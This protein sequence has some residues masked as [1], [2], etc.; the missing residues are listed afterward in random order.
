MNEGFIPLRIMKVDG[1]FDD[2]IVALRRTGSPGG[3]RSKSVTAGSLFFCPSIIPTGVWPR[4]LE[5]FRFF[6]RARCKKAPIDSFR[7]G[8]Q[9]LIA[10][11]S[12]W[13]HAR[14]VL[15]LLDGRWVT[16]SF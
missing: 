3:H 5:L 2:V 15:L 1:T 13:P 7:F 11:F 6:I 8:L 12:V 14:Q 9:A 16:P 10:R 4:V